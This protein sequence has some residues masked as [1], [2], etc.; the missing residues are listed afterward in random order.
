MRL[1][2]LRGPDILPQPFFENPSAH[3]AGGGPAQVL[4]DDADLLPSEIPNP[5]RHGIL[6]TAAFLVMRHLER[7]GLADVQDRLASQ[8][9]GFD[10]F[11]HPSTLLV[12]GPSSPYFARIDP[13]T[14]PLELRVLLLGHPPGGRSS[15]GSSSVGNLVPAARPT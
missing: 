5:L 15:Q 14:F 6:Q 9:F 1:P 10:R 8:A 3:L 13:G 4:V 12:P 7:R 2:R 11:T